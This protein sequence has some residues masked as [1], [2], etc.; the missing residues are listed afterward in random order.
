MLVER[1]DP[2][3]QA[4]CSSTY[5]A[6]WWTGARRSPG[7]PKKSSNPLG[8]SSIGWP[9]PTPGAANTSPG[10]RKCAPAGSPLPS[11]TCC[12]GATSYALLPRFDLQNLSDEVLDDLTLVWHR[13]DAWPDVPAA[14]ARLEAEIL[15]GAGVERQ[16]FAD[17]RSRAP[18]RISLG[19][20]PRRRNC[21]AT[22]S[23]SRASISP[24]ARRS[25][26]TP[27]QCM[28]VAAHSNDLAAAAKLGLRTAHTAR[29]ERIWTEHRR[30]RADRCRSISRRRIWP[31]W[32]TSSACNVSPDT[33]APAARRSSP[34]CDRPACSSSAGS[35]RAKC[36]P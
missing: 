24:P 29:V 28:M 26:S 35:W 22:T 7:R 14:L 8:I 32:P 33:P 36:R 3:L 19:R 2:R 4:P 34:G 5:S 21:A 30:G 1:P 16:H 23:R 17:G 25:I 12:T 9:L 18:Q 20:D 10:W 27:A 6:P 13:L 11:S 15:A 31:T